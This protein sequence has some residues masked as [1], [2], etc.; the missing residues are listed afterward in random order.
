MAFCGFYLF[1]IFLQKGPWNEAGKTPLAK[2]EI[3]QL[4][5][6]LRSGDHTK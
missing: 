1:F 3:E 6:D 2:D 5:H 4:I